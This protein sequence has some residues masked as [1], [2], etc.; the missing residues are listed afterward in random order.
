MSL[1]A[2]IMSFSIDAKENRFVAVANIPGAFLHT[3]MD[4]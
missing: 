4:E 1:E 2:M 3:D